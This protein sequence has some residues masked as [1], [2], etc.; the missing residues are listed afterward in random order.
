M[1]PSSAL[2]LL[3]VLAAVPWSAAPPD[4]A[5][6]MHVVAKAPFKA[7][8]ERD[9]V[10]LPAEY[11]EIQFWPEGYRDE[12]KVLEVVPPGRSVRTGDVVL[13][14]ETRNIDRAIRQGE[15]DLRAAEQRLKDARAELDVLDAD[16]EAELT[17]AG[18]DSRHAE[19]RLKN[20]IE[21]DKPFG[22]ED[23]AMSEQRFRNS[24]NDQEEELRQ[25]G[26]MYTEDELTEETEEIVLMRSRRDLEQSKKSFDMMQRKRVYAVEE[27]QPMQLEQLTLDAREKTRNLERVKRTQDSRKVQKRIEAERAAFDLEQK[28]DALEK[29][30]RDRDLFTVRA[31]RDGI[32]LHG[33]AD[34]AE[35][36]KLEKGGSVPMN[37]TIFTVAAP[38]KLR[39]RFTIPEASALEARGGMS[40][41]LKPVALPDEN[42]KGSLEPL[43]L[44]PSSRQG[45]NLWNATA[46]LASADD[47][48]VPG[49]KAKAE[50]VLEEIPDAI[51]VPKAAVHEKD[52]AKIVWVKN[53]DGTHAARPVKTGRSNATDTVVVDGLEAGVTIYLSEPKGEAK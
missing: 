48:L 40:A 7:T 6:A 42:L 53:E 22:D 50:I 11:A 16:L 26:K 20:W 51:T 21:K 39:A 9:A 17:R 52:G 3:F 37:S 34:S 2:L 5:P 27:Q 18:Q 29:L 38:G 24:I 31:P 23:Y 49:M 47:R 15:L 44:L 19:R 46:A 36:K 25:L 14:I 13:R 12:L 33:K 8:L 35:E 28:A 43:D 30:K 10:F 4:E 32:L 1:P 45:E 41:A